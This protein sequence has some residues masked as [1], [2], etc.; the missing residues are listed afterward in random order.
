MK[1][2]ITDKTISKLQEMINNGKSDSISVRKFNKEKDNISN[3]ISKIKLTD[4]QRI[5]HKKGTSYSVYINQER[6]EQVKKMIEEKPAGGIFPF[7]PLL[8]GGI[9]AL[10]G[11]IGAATG[12]ANTVLNKKNN[13]A[14]LEEEKRNNLEMEKIARGDGFQPTFSSGIFLNP[15]KNG[16]SLEVKDF[17]NGSGLD[18]I[19]KRT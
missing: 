7:L 18:D 6:L 8:L 2:F 10:T 1:I 12:I 11:G 3:M 17:V 13:E 16:M 14:K 15:W 5:K 9:G 4:Q 19:G